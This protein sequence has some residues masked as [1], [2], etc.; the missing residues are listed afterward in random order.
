MINIVKI[1]T[2]QLA[3]LTSLIYKGEYDIDNNLQTILLLVK[4]GEF[5]YNMTL[6]YQTIPS[7]KDANKITNLFQ[8][9]KTKIKS[10]YFVDITKL[11]NVY[12]SL[13]N[14]LEELLILYNSFTSITIDLSVDDLDIFYKTSLLILLNKR[15]FKI[16]KKNIKGEVKT[17]ILN[18]ISKLLINTL[19]SLTNELETLQD[20]Y[21]NLLINS[22][23]YPDK[24][25]FSDSIL[26]YHQEIMNCIELLKQ[27]TINKDKLLL[28]LSRLSDY[29]LY[30]IH[31]YEELNLL[32]TSKDYV[33]IVSLH[34]FNY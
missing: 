16:Y 20:Q 31:P 32:K 12:E 6:D 21:Q 15:Y 29:T 22:K 25:V 2:I 23:L 34:I 9:V 10:L 33:D 28:V 7:F 24:Y 1:F 4:H 30:I 17:L 18:S 19:S 8:D 5:I 3:E 14:D 13:K 27:K 11:N 26:I